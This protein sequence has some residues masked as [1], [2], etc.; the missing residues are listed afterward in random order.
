MPS[1]RVERELVLYCCCLCNSLHRN[2]H[3]MCIC[4]IGDRES[5]VGTATRYGLDD[6]GFQPQCW[7]DKHYL[8]AFSLIPVFTQRK[9][10][11]W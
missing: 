6:P 2:K 1:K 7:Q 10:T 3:D 9:K 4:I 5:S 8:S 11:T